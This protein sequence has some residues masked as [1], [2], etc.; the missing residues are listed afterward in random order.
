MSRLDGKKSDAIHGDIQ[1]SL[2]PSC[3]WDKSFFETEIRSIFRQSWISVGRFD[4]VPNRGDYLALEVG[5]IPLIITRDD[6]GNLNALANSCRH[7]G[8]QLLDP[9]RGHCQR[10]ICP[11]HGWS[12]A[13]DGSLLSAPKMSGVADF[14]LATY[15]L[16]R[17]PVEVRA[18]F[19]F[20]DPLGQAGDIDDWLGDFEALH[21]PW[22]I[23]RLLTGYDTSLE[24]GC[25][26]KAF[27]EVFNEY[28]HLPKVHPKSFSLY[29][30]TPDP[31][32]QVRGNFATQFG[33]HQGTRSVAKVSDGSKPLPIFP[34]LKGRNRNGTRYTWLFPGLSFAVSSDAL[35]SFIVEPLSPERTRVT[36]GVCF[37][38]EVMQEDDFA[39]RLAPYRQRMEEGLQEDLEV[40]KRL[41]HGLTSPLA[42]PGPYA[43]VLEDS[44]QQFHG[45]LR[46]R[47]PTIT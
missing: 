8:T 35:W 39:E 33:R 38:P 34:G 26:W 29:Y 24:V 37:A 17:I 19:I 44:V 27:L 31:G 15:P 20:V 3:Y 1:L 36:L 22:D 43:P 11:F 45:W 13:L 12:Y 25:N 10:I 14:D 41:Q 18:G 42:H 47:L 23:S 32:D 2:D 4:R 5:G 28:Y 6:A 30:A 21:M 7:R 16:Q 9:G 46:H 40:L